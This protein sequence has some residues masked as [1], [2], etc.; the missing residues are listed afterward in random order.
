MAYIDNLRTFIRAFELGSMSA[1]ARDLRISAAVASSRIGELEKHLGIRLFHRTTRSLKPTEQGT[2]FHAGAT[3]V[4]DA[5]IDAEQEI[6]EITN[7]PRGSIFIAAPLGLGK[8]LIAPSIPAFKEKYPGLNI[9][10]RLSDRRIDVVAEGLD[11]ALV[12]GTLSDSDLRVRHVRDFARVLC[13]SPGYVEHHGNPSN[14]REILDR[15]HQC[16]LLR[17]PG[18]RE[19]YWTLMVKGRLKRFD[20]GGALESDD[21][22]VLTGWALDGCGIVNKPRYEVAEHLASGKLVVVAEQTPP[23]PIPLSCV[24]PHKRLQDRKARLFMDHIVATCVNLPGD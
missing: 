13:A 19:F 21:G 1:A 16:L 10:L 12:L 18:A 2:M 17:Y 3:R 5:I 24:Y 11:L 15:Q 6:G 22:D 9:R 7:T 20:V 4:L 23:P 8:K 14:G